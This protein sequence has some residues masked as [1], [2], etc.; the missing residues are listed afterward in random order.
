[1]IYQRDPFEPH[2]GQNFTEAQREYS[3]IIAGEV[4]SGGEFGFR[5]RF[6]GYDALVES[7]YSRDGRPKIDIYYGPNGPLGPGHHHAVAYRETP[8]NFVYDGIRD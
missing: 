7:S 1:V 6:R 3:E 5:C 8:F 4:A 2:G